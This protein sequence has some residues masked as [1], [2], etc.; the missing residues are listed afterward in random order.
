MTIADMSAIV[1]ATY[2]PMPP[3]PFPDIGLDPDPNPTPD[4]FASTCDAYSPVF[5]TSTGDVILAFVDSG[6]QAG[7]PGTQFSVRVRAQTRPVAVP[8]STWSFGIVAEGCKIV[9]TTYEGTVAEDAN[10][11]NRAT[12]QKL[13]IAFAETLAEGGAISFVTFDYPLPRFE[14]CATELSVGTA[15]D[16]LELEVRVTVPPSGCQECVLSYVE[17]LRGSGQ[18]VAIRARTTGRT[19][20]PSLES[21]RFNVCVGGVQIPGD[22]NQDG[23]LDLSDGICLLN[24]LFLGTGAPLPCGDGSPLHAGNLALLN[25]NDDGILDLSDAVRLFGYLFLGGPPHPLG[26]GCVS[27][28]GCPT[29]ATNDD[30][31][32][33]GICTAQGDNCPAA[34]NPGQEDADGDG[35]G[36]VCDFCPTELVLQADGVEDGSLDCDLAPPEGHFPCATANQVNRILCVDGADWNNDGTIGLD[37][38]EGIFRSMFCNGG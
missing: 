24:F 3:P 27:I 34:Y 20:L 1:D 37:D 11:G 32:R 15:H 26:T 4:G 6:E 36:D 28:A 10:I 13:G 38:L 5:L 18:P 22:C 9:G 12:N 33:D 21:L 35:V 17:G 29:L 7:S 30:G 23:T 19:I 16:V 14:D 31:D 2:W 25:F 8:V